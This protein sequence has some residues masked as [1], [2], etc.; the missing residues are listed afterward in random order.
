M[1]RKDGKRKLR[2]KEGLTKKE[3]KFVREYLKDFNGTRAYL[4]TY[5]MGESCKINS[6]GASACAMLQKHNVMVEI[7]NNVNSMMSNLE[8]TNEAIL[9]Q[10]IILAFMDT[11]SLFNEDGSFKEIR[12]LNIAQQAVIESI[13]IDELFSGS[14][15]DRI[16]IGKR[17]KVKF[18]SKQKAIDNLMKYKKLIGDN[19]ITLNK[20]EINLTIASERLKEKLGA[21]GIV[22]LA[23]KLQATG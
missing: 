3:K 12:E 6:A 17:K 19:N 4:A 2:K 14:G 13:E 7:D 1:V 22:E 5:P 21:D 20:N 18:Y 11:R 8:L 15:D 16:Q 10:Q 9:G 23:E